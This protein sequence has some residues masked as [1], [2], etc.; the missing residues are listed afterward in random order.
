MRGQKVLDWI[1]SWI[2]FSFVIIVPKYLNCATFSTICY[3]PLCHNFALD[4]GDETATFSVCTSRPISLLV[5]IKVCVSFRILFGI[6]KIAYQWKESIIIPIHKKG[7]KTDS[8]NYRGTS[9]LSTLYKIVS[10]V[11]L[12]GLSPYVDEIIGDH[13]CAFRCNRSTTEQIFCIRQILENIWEYN[14]TGH[15]VFGELKSKAYV[16]ARR[17]LLY[18]ILIEFGVPIILVRLIKMCLKKIYSNAHIDKN[19]S[20][21]FPTRSK[22]RRCF[23]ATAFQLCFRMCH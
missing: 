11:L 8:S 5:S 21:S 19:L 14:E 3:L 15:Q 20:D 2:R 10:N 23:I 17:E 22:T 1:S 6:Q 18:N 12:S 7:D 4:Y 13:Q 16:S 9:L